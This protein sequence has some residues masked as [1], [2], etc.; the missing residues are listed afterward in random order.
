M[1]LLE[2]VTPSQVN[3]STMDMPAPLLNA[4][5]R[6]PMALE[7]AWIR[8]GGALPFGLSIICLARSGVAAAAAPGKPHQGARFIEPTSSS[9]AYDNLTHR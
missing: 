6:L 7:A 3:D 1:R 2:R 8:G 9:L 5:L 4:A